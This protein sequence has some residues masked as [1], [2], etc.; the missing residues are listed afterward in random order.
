VSSWFR[1]PAP[2]LP[3]PSLAVLSNGALSS[4]GGSPSP[5]PSSGCAGKP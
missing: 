2:V 3:L 1:V 4:L 5:A